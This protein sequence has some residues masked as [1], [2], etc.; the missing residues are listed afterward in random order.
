MGRRLAPDYSGLRIVHLN[1]AVDWRGGERQTLF[2]AD[3]LRQ[4]GIE[5]VVVG[6]P[7]SELERRCARRAI[8]FAPLRIRGELDPFSWR[9]LARLAADFRA[10]HLHAHTARAHAVALF[11]RRSLPDTALIVSRRVDFPRRPNLLSRWKYQTPLVTRYLAISENVRRILIADGINEQ[12]ISVAYSGVD[13]DVYRQRRDRQK[14]RREFSFG[15][16]DVIIGH[17]AALV[18]HKDQATLLR[19]F[20]HALRGAPRGLQLRL[21][22]LGEGPLRRELE[23]LARELSLSDSGALFMPGWR[24]DIDDWL[25]GFD[26]FALSSKEEGLGTA[27]LDAMGHGLALAATD[28][29]GIPEMVVHGKGGLLSPPG[30]AVALGNHMLQLSLKPKLRKQFGQFNQKRVQL[31]SKAA[32]CEATLRCYLQAAEQIASEA[33]R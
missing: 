27:A 14:V 7:R 11:A 18:D 15:P 4:R 12:R 26:L 33:R 6:Q 3:E 2:L 9:A 22:V 17:A 29:G 25:A 23:E 28:A 19:A 5:Q 24:A 1:T 10:S 16:K 32:T 8:P 20:A 21:V 30:D 13:L 31:F